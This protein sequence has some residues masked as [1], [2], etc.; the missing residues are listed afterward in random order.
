MGVSL[1]GS[2]Q[3]LSAA[4]RVRATPFARGQ[5]APAGG[6][7]CSTRAPPTGGDVRLWP[8]PAMP[9]WRARRARRAAR[10]LAPTRRGKAR[11]PR[12]SMASRRLWP[13]Q[14]SAVPAG[15]P[16]RRTCAQRVRRTPTRDPTAPR[17][18]PRSALTISAAADGTGHARSAPAAC[19]T[20]QA[21][22]CSSS[23][24]TRSLSPG[25]CPAGHRH[26]LLDSAVPSFR[27]ATRSSVLSSRPRSALPLQS[28]ARA[29]AS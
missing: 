7:R 19:W 10:G 12:Y 4:A 24:T 17:F 23:R 16:A 11:P 1:R 26:L 6:L 15:G 9:G 22:T 2:D 8:A 20:R 14:A 13:S 27:R 5:Y 25:A 18:G 3:A 29:S 21:L 28:S